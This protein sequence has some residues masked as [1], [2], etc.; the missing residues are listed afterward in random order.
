MLLLDY[1]DMLVDFSPVP[2]NAL[3]TE[4]LVNCLLNLTNRQNTRLIIIT[5]REHHDIETKLGNLPIDIVAE[6]EAMIRE[7]GI[8]R[9]VLT[10]NDSWKNEFL[11]LLNNASLTCTGSFV[12]EKQFSITWHYRTVDPVKGLVLSRKLIRILESSL[13][14]HNLKIIDGNKVIEIMSKKISKGITTRHLLMQRHYDFVLA[15]EDDK[16]DEDMFEAISDNPDYY[17]F[18]VG[19]GNS[20]AMYTVDNIEQV[21][22]LLE[23]L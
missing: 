4:R 23:K 19:K 16:T 17:S 11:P 21:L 15:I 6:H 13:A 12:E 10:N 7:N 1:D 2:S 18:K 3:P 20:I 5:G 9:N 14:A 8:W 22:K